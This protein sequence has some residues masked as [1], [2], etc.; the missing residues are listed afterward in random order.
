MEL[1]RYYALVL[2]TAFTRS[3]SLAQDII[4]GAIILVGCAIWLVPQM[5]AQLTTWA[6]ALNGWAI[7]ATVLA[8]I[9]AIRLL[10]SPYWIYQEQADIIKKERERKEELERCIK[11]K[12]EVS[13]DK[14]N[15]NC[16]GITPIEIIGPHPQIGLSRTQCR[17]FRLRVVNIGE[18]ALARCNGYLKEVVN[19]KTGEKVESPRLLWASGPS[20]VPEVTLPPNVPMYLELCLV[21]ESNKIAVTTEG[22]GWPFSH[23]AM[24]DDIGQYLFTV[25]IGSDNMVWRTFSTKLNWTGDW[26]TVNMVAC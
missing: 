7:A 23:E 3:L 17:F 12:I 26:K 2:R 19:L 8:S 18:F 21:H 15:Q 13:Y 22:R 14:D 20:G 4:F 25:S 24:F 9:I 16:C 11:P 5:S 1:L 10:L 6:T